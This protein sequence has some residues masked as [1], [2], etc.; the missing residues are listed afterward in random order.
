MRFHQV[1]STAFAPNP[2]GAEELPKG[3]CPVFR[4]PLLPKDACSDHLP[5]PAKPKPTFGCKP[6]P[7]SCCEGARRAEAA[8]KRVQDALAKS[9]ILQLFQKS[10]TTEAAMPSFLALT[11]SVSRNC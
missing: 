2:G 6:E 7:P 8:L 10:G 5:I 11:A 1:L 9:P 3:D 4:P